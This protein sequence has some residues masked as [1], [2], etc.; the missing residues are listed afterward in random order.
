MAASFFVRKI[1]E[2]S[3]LLLS[4]NTDG[5]YNAMI[6][7]T[8]ASRCSRGDEALPFLLGALLQ[9]TIALIRTVMGYVN[10][11]L[12]KRTTSRHVKFCFDELMQKKGYFYALFTVAQ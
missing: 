10:V 8:L 2:H 7:M 3:R 4:Q 5:I 1:L 9:N 6:G 12:E 11:F